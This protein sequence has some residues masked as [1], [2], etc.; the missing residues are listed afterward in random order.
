[1]TLCPVATVPAVTVKVA[2]AEPTPTVTLAGAVNAVLLL[3]T[4]IVIALEAALLRL[5]VQVAAAAAPKVLG[6]QLSPLNCAGALRFRV[7]FCVTPLEL[8]D[9]A[10]V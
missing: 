3:A 1:M 10:A 7:K 2:A 5:T 4:P 6:V 9:R 8:A